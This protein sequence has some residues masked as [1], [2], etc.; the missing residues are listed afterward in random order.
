MRKVIL[1][2]LLTPGVWLVRSRLRFLAKCYLRAVE[3][4][5]LVLASQ[6]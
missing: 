1:Y 3:P 4:V 5:V 2:A 6:R